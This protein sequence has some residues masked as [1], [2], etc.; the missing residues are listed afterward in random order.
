[1]IEFDDLPFNE[2]V[3]KLKTQLN[4]LNGTELGKKLNNLT[5][6]NKYPEKPVLGWID[7]RNVF[8]KVS[9]IIDLLYYD[10]GK[11]YILD[12]KTDADESYLNYYKIQVQTYQW[13]VKQLYG[14]EAEGEIYFSA[15][16]ELIKVNWD[17]SYF[18][19]IYPEENE[20]F[21]FT[22]LPRLPL[23]N[24]IV[25]I[26]ENTNQPVFIINPTRNHSTRLIQALSA[27]DLLKPSI[28]ITAVNELI[29]SHHVNGRRLSPHQYR[30]M[31]QKLNENSE[32]PRGEIT[33]LTDASVVNEEWGTALSEP[34]NDIP[35]KIAVLKKS[36][37]W[38]S[39]MDI[40]KDLTNSKKFAGKTV[41]LNGFYNLSPPYFELM[42]KIAASAD[43]FYFTDNFD[44]GKIKTTF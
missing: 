13:M 29:Q 33:F 17:E 19:K 2:T 18:T 36:G 10:N 28:S 27:R 25:K 44:K 3:E 15:S 38:F 31:I 9:G 32:V 39:D 12:F 34:Y 16:G 6:E 22:N 14:I 11:W 8:L 23:N 43:K 30:L 37:K 26:I 7:N 4:I 42:K 40:L 21:R 35:E 20:I 5:G 1:E 41:I 24:E